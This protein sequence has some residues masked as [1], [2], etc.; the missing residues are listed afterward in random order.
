MPFRAG[1]FDGAISIRYTNIR[2]H[3]GDMGE[4][5]PFRA[6]TFDGAISIRYKIVFG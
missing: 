5:M 4:G 6:G 3:L 1:T 2:F